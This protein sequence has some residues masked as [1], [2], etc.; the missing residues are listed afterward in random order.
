MLARGLLAAVIAQFLV[1]VTAF[2]QVDAR[3]FR[4]PGRGRSCNNTVVGFSLSSGAFFGGM[5]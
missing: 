5:P 1:A 3:M 4:F 2:A